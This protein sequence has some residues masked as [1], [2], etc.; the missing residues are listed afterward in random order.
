MI[1]DITGETKWSDMP[2][3]TLSTAASST[4]KVILQPIQYNGSVVVATSANSIA[5]GLVAVAGI[6]NT[7]NTT[8]IGFI[9]TD[10]VSPA[11]G[12]KAKV[13]IRD[14]VTNQPILDS[15][16]RK[17][18]GVAYNDGSD[19]I[20]IK[21]FVINSSNIAEPYTFTA[22]TTIETILP[23]RI[24]L[25]DANEDFL[26]VNGGW[27]DEVGALEVG[28]RVY[29]DGLLNDGT[30]A[31]YGFVTDEDITSTINK[32]AAIG[33]VDKNLGD[34]VSSVTGI[35]SS[36]FVSTFLTD[37]TNS[38]LSDGDTLYNAI[39]KLDAQAKINADAAASA[40]ADKIMEIVSTQIAESVAHT[41]PQTKTYLNTDKDALTVY[42]NGQ[43][44]VSNAIAD[45]NNSG[46]LGDYSES[47]TT[48][49]TF[50]F[51]IEVGDVL[52]YE[53]YKV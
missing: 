5:T 15:Q 20:E 13:S 46:D 4:N 30:T 34:N 2:A 17:V 12:S 25:V 29:V 18:F 40:Q 7:T 37:N 42:V 52:V 48:E 10:S 31:T 35:S 11:E 23:S 44:L 32:L 27:A 36:T 51:P 41:L 50:N 38:F 6:L 16:E 3:V 49:I 47:S 28:D 43:A 14:A 26:M 8:D 22:D 21:F 45:A 24:N 9:V 53:I 1:L 19:N 39:E 33:I